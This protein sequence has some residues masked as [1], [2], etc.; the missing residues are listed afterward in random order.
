MTERGVG[1]TTDRE[2]SLVEILDRALGAGVVLTGDVT[3]S[4]ADV[5]LVYLSLRLL[6]GSV[7]TIEDGRYDAD[8]DAVSIGR[9]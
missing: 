8:A 4:L 6:V 1:L 2:V 5:D 9:G 7:G 3:I